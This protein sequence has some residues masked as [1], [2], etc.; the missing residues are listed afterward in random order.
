MLDAKYLREV[1][2]TL[3]RIFHDAV[4]SGGL[5]TIA[6]ARL[7]SIL[8]TPLAAKIIAGEVVGGENLWCAQPWLMESTQMW[9]KLIYRFEGMTEMINGAFMDDLGEFL[10]SVTGQQRKTLFEIDQ[11]FEK[12][13]ERLIKNFATIKS[14]MPFLR[15]SLRQTMIRKL[16]KVGK[17]KEAWEK[18]EE[19]LTQ[20]QDDEHMLTLEDTAV[21]IKRAE[22]YLHR[23]DGAGAAVKDKVAF[24]ADVGDAED[25]TPS[26]LPWKRKSRPCKNSCAET[27]QEQS[28]A[29]M[30]Y[31]CRRRLC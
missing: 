22:Q 27:Q 4:F 18:A 17:D 26:S 20:L 12:M 21:A 14:L 1:N 5:E 24:K 16:G 10:S 30:V 11:E 31:Q 29:A 25:P 28:A 13:C 6:T 19:Y 23:N 9:A 3:A 15:S 2:R 8:K 7:R